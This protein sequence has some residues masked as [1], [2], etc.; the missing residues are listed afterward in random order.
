MRREIS[1][2]YAVT[3]DT[4]DTRRLLEKVE[5]VL[6]GGARLVQYRSKIAGPE[7][8][9]VQARAVLA[10]C[11]ARRVPLII[12]DHLDLALDAD[13]DGLHVGKD[14]GSVR[15]ARKKLGP[16]KL[17]GASCYNRIDA[18]LEAAEA[19]AD[20]VAFGSFFP[21][22]SK[23]DAVRA[24]LELLR[25]ARRRLRVPVVAIGGITPDNAG[26]LIAAGADAVAVIAAIFEAPDTGAAA[27][28]FHAL[29]RQ[30]AG[31]SGARERR[32]V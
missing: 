32:A 24:P 31:G 4:D 17:L 6:D 20:H 19:G 3:P 25:E 30:R 16:G 21:S 26:E 13:A 2:L 10:L 11:R 27:R 12:N 15:E 7:L 1:G 8:R 28:R 9:Y 22:G 23:P 14:D 5:A 29:F 18:A